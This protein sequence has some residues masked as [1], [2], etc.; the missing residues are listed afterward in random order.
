VKTSKLAKVVQF[1][2]G[3]YGIKIGANYAQ[4]YRKKAKKYNI[5]NPATLVS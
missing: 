2:F 1:I 5:L 4:I 3:T